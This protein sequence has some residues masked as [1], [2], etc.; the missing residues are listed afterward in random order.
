M[1][2]P[3]TFVTFEVDLPDDVELSEAGD[4]VIP[5]GRNVCNELI[6]MLKSEGVKVS[7]PI[8]RDYYGWEVSIQLRDQ[9]FWILLQGGERWLLL[10]ERRS[11][12]L[13]W[14]G[15]SKKTAFHEF[16]TLLSAAMKK[17]KRFRNVSWSS[18]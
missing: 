16:L 15:K 11:G 18:A 13:R 1:I 3:Q 12:V 7:D 9:K 10:V 4:I 8:Q 14:I 17:D 6:Q 5:G 2:D